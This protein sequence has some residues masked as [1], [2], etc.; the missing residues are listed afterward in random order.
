M[1]GP[2]RFPQERLSG[3]C[4]GLFFSPLAL[5][6]VPFFV[7]VSRGSFLSSPF[8]P[9]RGGPAARLVARARARFR[10]LVAVR[11]RVRPGRWRLSLALARVVSLVL[12]RGFR[13]RFRLFRSRRS[14]CRAGVF[15][16]RVPGLRGAPH[17]GVLAGLGRF[18]PGGCFASAPG[19]AALALGWPAVAGFVGR[20]SPWRLAG[21]RSLPRACPRVARRSRPGRAVPACC[22][23][24]VPPRWPP[25]P[26]FAAPGCSGFG[27]P[28][29]CPRWPAGGSRSRPPSPPRFPVGL[30]LAPRRSR[31]AP[32]ASG[33]FSNFLRLVGAKR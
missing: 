27:S 16:V 21:W 12:W 18:G 14:V 4:G 31:R 13:R 5:L 8:L 2:S 19:S 9:S 22:W 1:G 33:F 25:P 23:W 29:R 11:R 15:L 7:G 26:P 30:A 17:G 24:P 20:G 32:P 3:G 10:A 6:P 28:V